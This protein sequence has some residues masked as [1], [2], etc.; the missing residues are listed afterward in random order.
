[1]LHTPRRLGALVAASALALSGVSLLASPAQAA[2]P[3]QDPRPV[4]IAATWLTGQLT[5]GLINNSQY[6]F[7]DY[8]LTI[9]TG[10][11]LAAVGGH[12]STVNAIADALAPHIFGSTGYTESDEYA[13][14][15]PYA[16][17]QRGHY[18]GAAAKALVFAEATGQDP[19]TWGGSNLVDAVEA[20]VATAAPI[21]GRIADDSSYGDYANSIG[22]AYA[23][24]G[25][26][27]AGSTKA[28]SVLSFLLKQQCAD[29]YFRLS[30]TA[31]KTATDQTCDGGTAGGASDPDVDVTAIATIQLEAISALLPA[32]ATQDAV[33]A[34]I[35]N[36]GIWLVGAQQADGSFGGSGPTA[37]SNT[38][39][40]GLAGW[41]L[42]TLGDVS[43]ASHAAVWIRTHQ[44]DD[45]AGCTTAL[46]SSQGALA[47]DDAALA[48]GRTA[49]ITTATQD[50]WRRA[51]A[52]TLP[53]LDYAPAATSSPKVT[54]PTGF[55]KAGTTATYHVSGYAPGDSLCVDAFGTRKHVVA[56]AQGD[57]TVA[58]KVP[59]GT[60][61]RTVSVK[62]GA[63][64]SAAV[65]TNALGTK[66]FSITGAHRVARGDSV[67]MT[68]HGLRAG[69][70][71]TVNF[72]GSPVAAGVAGPKGRFFATFSV[73]RKLGK[74]KVAAFGQFSDIR[75]GSTTV[76]VVR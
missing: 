53:V 54:G 47:Y 11:S 5:D 27:F 34:A 9:D 20:R 69:E 32:G 2:T 10:I 48:T 19:T 59:A 22:E 63:N 21:A 37:A 62:D 52:P 71:V 67:T 73:G 46:A 4:D 74:A 18:A 60:T 70:H 65:T 76:K 25:L 1:M 50:Q 58:A 29:G 51:T 57:A 64:A 15:P 16:L 6:D 23:A 61:V 49:G 8:G 28:G 17:V 13:S 66:T 38:N 42:G 12:T 31:D 72:R 55:V 26:E 36:A 30:M 3:T 43:A 14:S 45:P 75:H 44:V 7:D 39:S 40:T 33:T 68:V 41:A 24:L 35:Q 56:D